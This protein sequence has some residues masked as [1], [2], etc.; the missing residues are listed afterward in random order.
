MYVRAVV[1]EHVAYIWET[2]LA[3][4][5]EYVGLHTWITVMEAVLRKWIL[6]LDHNKGT[7]FDAK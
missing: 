6:N 1:S 5:F 4:T 7:I 3:T 2:Y